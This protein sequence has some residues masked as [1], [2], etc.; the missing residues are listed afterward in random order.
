MAPPITLDIMTFLLG[1]PMR[2]SI[3]PRRSHENIAQI[4][5]QQGDASQ[6]KQKQVRFAHTRRLHFFT[7]AIRRP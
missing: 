5:A 3:R 1:P 6:P 4:K 7:K 2:A